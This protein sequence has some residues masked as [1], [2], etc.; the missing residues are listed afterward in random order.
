MQIAVKVYAWI[1]KFPGKSVWRGKSEWKQ[2]EEWRIVLNM[3]I[4]FLGQILPL[5]ENQKN[6]ALVS[7]NSACRTDRVQTNF[8]LG[9]KSKSIPRWEPPLKQKVRAALSSLFKTHEMFKAIRNMGKSL[10]QCYFHLGGLAGYLHQ[11]KLPAFPFPL[12]NV[13]LLC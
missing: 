2:A 8:P 13:W 6:P 1:Q 5:G 3:S 4:L 12:W 11:G 9:Q 10:S 7:E